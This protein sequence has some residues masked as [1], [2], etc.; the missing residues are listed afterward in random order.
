[1][2]K[3]K[4]AKKSSQHKAEA[5]GDNGVSAPK[6]VDFK[7]D[8]KPATGNNK[9]PGLKPSPSMNTLSRLDREKVVIWRRPLDTLHYAVAELICL[10]CEG[11]VGLL[12]YR[13]FLTLFSALSAVVTYAYVTPGPHQEYVGVIESKLLWWSWWVLLGVLSSIGLGSGLHT[14]LLYLGPH[15]AAVTLAAY[16]C[17]SLDFPEPPYPDS[18]VC[19]STTT[20]AAITLWNIVAKIRVE[21]FLWGVGTAI[22]ELPPYFM[23][24]AARLSGN[25]PD[26]EEYREFLELLEAGK[27]NTGQM[28]LVDRAKAWM[29]KTVAKVGF[30]GILACASVPNPLFD[31]AGITC[32]HF[33]V[34]FWT[35]FGATVIGKAVVKMHVQMLFVIVVFSA[36]HVEQLLRLLEG[37]PEFG[38]MLRGPIEDFLAKQKKA[39]HREPGTNVEAKSSLV[40]DLM[41]LLVSTMIF[42]FL[43]TLI[44]GLAQSYHKRLYERTKAK[45]K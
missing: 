8:A 12:Q 10:I 40:S 41:G 23:A 19:P 22:G 4:A 39:L 30:F 7:N 44:N 31:L 1:M 5:A 15:I 28:S 2:G 26:D 35:F 24:R 33:L 38:S 20:G 18:I 27:G 37:I 42:Y 45:S 3:T 34:P 43:V 13:I 9:P 16:E 6:R 25:E 36:H 32:G 29:E 14:F 17:N 21:A 11:L